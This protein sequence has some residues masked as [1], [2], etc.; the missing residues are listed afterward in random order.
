MTEFAYNNAKNASTGHMLFELNDKY[1]PKM[2]YEE[3][4]DLHSKLKLVDK[5]LAELQE[6]MTVCHKNFYHAQE[7]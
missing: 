1:Y 6:L 3:D 2:F 4:I 7:L 5:L